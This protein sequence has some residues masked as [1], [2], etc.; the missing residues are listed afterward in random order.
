MTS[1][2]KTPEKQFIQTLDFIEILLLE[3]FEANN[4]SISFP[5]L[6]IECHKQLILN[7][8]DVSI[9]QIRHSAHDLFLDGWIPILV[10]PQKNHNLQ[11]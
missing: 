2:S 11:Q 10:T 8:I 1:E 7:G 6:L 5:Q 3:I 9:E 4:E